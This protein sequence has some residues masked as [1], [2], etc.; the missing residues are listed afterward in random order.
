MGKTPEGVILGMEDKVWMQ[1]GDRYVVEI[2]GL[3]K[4]ENQIVE[5]S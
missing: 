2:E 4:L 3:V 5:V 1:A